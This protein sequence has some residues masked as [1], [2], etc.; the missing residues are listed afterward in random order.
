MSRIR[1]SKFL[2]YFAFGAIAATLQV[3][4]LTTLVEVAHLD[5]MIAS[6]T[7]FYIAV[8]VN[9][10]LQSYYTF[11]SVESHW[12]AMPKFISVS[13]IGAGINALTFFLLMKVMHYFPAQCTALLIVFIFN[14]SISK[15]LI[16]RRT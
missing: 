12:I 2:R 3:A 11:R 13:T 7:A 16:F 14:Y 5:K 15:T 6:I 8:V 1:E 10:F 9:Y 4:T